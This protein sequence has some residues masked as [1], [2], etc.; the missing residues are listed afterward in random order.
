MNRPRRA[1]LLFVACAAVLFGAMAWIS[2]DLL[3]LERS[4]RRARHEAAMEEAVR[5]ALWRMD[6]ALAPILARHSA[7]A[8]YTY[9][10]FYPAAFNG[11][12]ALTATAGWMA[13]TPFLTEEDPFVRLHFRVGGDGL[14]RSPQVPQAACDAQR[15]TDYA[16]EAQ[17]DSWRVELQ[18]L[19][20]LLDRDRLVAALDAPILP[21][22]VAEA[23]PPPQQAEV[24]RAN[25]SASEA[26]QAMNVQEMV[27]RAQTANQMVMTQQATVNYY[28]PPTLHV[29]G[30]ATPVWIQDELLLA[31]RVA[32]GRGDEIQGAWM[33]W[34]GL[35]RWLAEQV[36]DLLPDAALE[37][38][39]GGSIDPSGRSL[40]GLPA[41]LVP[42]DIPA[43]AVEDVTSP[44]PLTLIVAWL[45]VLIAV[46]AVAGLLAG[47]ISLSE[48]RAAFVSAVTHEMR[49]PLTTFRMYSEMLANGMVAPDKREGYLRTLQREAD[50]LGHLVENVL[51]YA[52]LE[53]GR[54][55]STV[56]GISLRAV[57]GRSLPRLEDRADQAD[58]QLVVDE[59]GRHG[60][61]QVQADASRVDQILL[62]LVDNACKYGTGGADATIRLDIET[63]GAV[64]GILVSDDGAGVA[65][66]DRR[67]LF[68]PFDKSA[69]EA[70][71]TAPGVGLGLSI[72]RRLA[73]DMG[74]DLRY[75][76]TH[77]PGATFLLTLR[78]V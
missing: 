41:R 46:G 66:G 32:T 62:N 75:V 54:R 30:L 71:H 78:S 26:Q 63:R 51:A 31:R 19:A 15:A 65:P 37:P 22:R 34:P 10:T 44:V 53:R 60:D 1:I 2:A 67:R 49:T 21:L 70:A 58:M 29:T 76:E 73:R 9:E 28:N 72:S 8:T 68:R 64:V 7:L 25:S 33:D 77:D 38:I 69:E 13:P 4:E 24:A 40:A 47:V 50:R 17:L 14:V 56:E 5:L 39:D 16:S 52:R 74:G 11:A 48:R 61:V 27:A 59:D 12:L 23:D 3:E 20:G 43:G 36:A 42:G 55:A 35:E 18:T 6:S 57:L 45:A